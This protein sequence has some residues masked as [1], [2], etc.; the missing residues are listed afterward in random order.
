MAAAPAPVPTVVQAEQAPPP[1]ASFGPEILLPD[2]VAEDREVARIGDTVLRQS[3]AFSRLLSADPKLALSAVDLLVFDVLIAQ[4]A[5][6]HDV[7]VPDERV[8]EL[9]AAEEQALR[10]QVE[11]EF[12]GRIAF[13]DYVWR[14]FGM[15]LFDW[16]NSTQLRV[17]QRL[18][19]GY[20]IRYLLLRQDR[21][22][23]RYIANKDRRALEEAREMALQGADFGT[24][25][26]RLSE[27]PLRREGGLLPAFGKGFTHPVA[28]VA[29]S[30]EPGQVS[31]VFERTVGGDRRC[32]L[33]FCKERLVAKEQPFAALRAEIDRSLVERPLSPIE[34][35]AFTLQWRGAVEA[36]NDD[37]RQPNR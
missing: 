21:V 16:R 8:R 37:N 34:T 7:T 22:V 26:Q 27:D 24:L 14:I 30:L 18:Y 5:K 6:A 12:G 28:D 17:A 4:Q 35:N 36:K 3:Q 29:L 13:E 9:A 2:P 31:E 25:A 15:R 32:Y 20:V 1:I 11:S 19:Q 10:T 23:V 33:V